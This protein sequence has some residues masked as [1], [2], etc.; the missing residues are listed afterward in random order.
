MFYIF[1]TSI[2]FITSI[3]TKRW[4]A[5][6]RQTSIVIFIS[7]ATLMIAITW[8]LSIRII[9]LKCF[10]TYARTAHAIFLTRISRTAE[11]NEYHSEFI[12]RY[13]VYLH[14]IRDIRL[15]SWI[16]NYAALSEMHIRT[17]L[18][19]PWTWGGGG[20]IIWVMRG[21]PPCFPLPSDIP[22]LPFSRPHVHRTRGCFVHCV[23]FVK[24]RV[25]LPTARSAR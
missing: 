9:A 15:S 16:S 23:S 13:I 17:I 12:D 3:Y 21:C 4:I 24:F 19:I 25:R 6:D 2:S 7:Y 14:Y 5:E 10:R 20:R 8:S 22:R 1:V 11:H 18:R